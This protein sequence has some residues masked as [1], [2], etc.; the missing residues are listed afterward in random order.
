MA[1]KKRGLGDKDF[2][3]RRE[4]AESL[5]RSL[6]RKC[7]SKKRYKT[8]QLATAAKFLVKKHL[9]SKQRVY[10]CPV[11]RFYHLTSQQS[12]DP[13]KIP[14][15]K[16][17]EEIQEPVSCSVEITQEASVDTVGGLS[18]VFGGQRK[19]LVLDFRMMAVEGET[20]P[21]FEITYPDPE[22]VHDESG[23][24][25]EG[26]W[27]MVNGPHPANT[28]IFFKTS[29]GEVQEWLGGSEDEYVCSDS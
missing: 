4:N 29:E 12:W 2:Q 28:R 22:D 8:R 26:I 13:D 19:G 16:K 7:K 14:E 25:Q 15:R 20:L 10:R 6:Q 18:I 1:R 3:R 17:V 21:Y 23:E 9:G 5:P 27:E 24:I 11:C